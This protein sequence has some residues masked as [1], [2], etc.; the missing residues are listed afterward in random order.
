MLLSLLTLRSFQSV[1]KVCFSVQFVFGIE[2]LLGTLNF[3][4]PKNVYF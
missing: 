4:F 3:Y 2:Y 1:E